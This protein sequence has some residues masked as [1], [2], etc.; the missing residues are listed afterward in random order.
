M[1]LE[2]IIIPP[3]PLFSSIDCE[4][5][6]ISYSDIDIKLLSFFSPSELAN[7][8]LIHE[9]AK[10]TQEASVARF[11]ASAVHHEH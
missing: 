3:D 5:T 1:S 2:S 10:R 9:F 4:G 11:M 8:W 6:A 7:T